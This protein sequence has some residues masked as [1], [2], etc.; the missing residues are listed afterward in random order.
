MLTFILLTID[1]HDPIDIILMIC[2]VLVIAWLLDAG[3]SNTSRK[4]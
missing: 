3:K 4:D 2:I 1:P